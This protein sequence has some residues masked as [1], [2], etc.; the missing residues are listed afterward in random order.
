MSSIVQP[1]SD[2][3]AKLATLTVTN[4]DAQAVPIYARIWNNQVKFEA[5]GKLYDYPKPACF[6]EVI[7]KAEYKEIG[8]GYRACDIGWRFHLV[9]EYLNQDGTFEQDLEIFDLKDKIVALFALYQPIGCGPMVCVAESQEYDHANIYHWILDFICHFIDS[10]GSWY[11]DAAGKYI[12]YGPPT[13]LDIEATETANRNIFI[14]SETTP[15][16][17]DDE[18]ES[19]LI[20]E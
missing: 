15:E 11:D 16:S 3:L 20:L 19:P 5:E 1:I 18:T 6:V 4:R 14:Q 10:K 2:V 12:Y 9:H 13:T 8:I 17:V 7:D